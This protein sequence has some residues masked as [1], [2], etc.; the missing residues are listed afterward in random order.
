M[1]KWEQQLAEQQRQ[2][3][4]VERKQEFLNILK[5]LQFTSEA[6]LKPSCAELVRFPFVSD[7][8]EEDGAQVPVTRERVDT[9]FD[10]LSTVVE[11]FNTKVLTDLFCK[12][13]ASS[14]EDDLRIVRSKAMLKSAATLFRCTMC[15]DRP[16]FPFAAL[17]QHFNQ[18]HYTV[19]STWERNCCF[20]YYQR[21]ASEIAAQIFAV[22]GLPDNSPAESLERNAKIVC[23]CGKPGFE[24]PAT[25]S[26]LVC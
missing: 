1:Q 25:L 26:K 2:G 17:L 21:A 15:G 7:L 16:M 18:A 12:L 22:V 19:H 9:I 3:R 14:P 11:E 5:Q 6:A 13:P 24:Q 8:L 20:I 23:L 10:A 4:L